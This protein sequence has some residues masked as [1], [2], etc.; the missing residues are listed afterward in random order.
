VF[1]GFG[2]GT[3]GNLARS[4]PTFETAAA[5]ALAR[6]GKFAKKG[7]TK[8]KCSEYIIWYLVL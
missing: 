6:G 3:F 4:N 2:K 5:T 7:D 1:H 8:E